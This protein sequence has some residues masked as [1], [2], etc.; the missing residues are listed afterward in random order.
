MATAI[1]Q[2]HLRRRESRSRVTFG[3][4]VDD[5]LKRVGALESA[6]AGITA[7]FEHL[8][9][10]A[11]VSDVRAS[12]HALEAAIIKWIIGTVL[13]TATLTFAIAKYIG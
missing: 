3:D 1:E 10:K 2:D 13:A 5:I 11:D 7:K 6:V 9:T 12:I 8:A 4:I